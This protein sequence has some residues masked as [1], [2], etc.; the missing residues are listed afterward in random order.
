MS[1]SML[2]TIQ[3]GLFDAFDTM[4]VADGYNYNVSGGYGVQYQ[5]E[6][7]NKAQF[8]LYNVYVINEESMD[9][10]VFPNMN[11]FRN[12]ATIEIHCYNKLADESSNSVFDID[13]VLNYM[14]HDIK[15]MIGSNRTL[16]STCESIFYKR[17][18][19]VDS[20]GREDI[21]L[22]K[23]LIITAEINY[24]QDDRTPSVAAY[25]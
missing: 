6:D 8:P 9:E 11:S 16:G 17:S 18:E 4:L 1:V 20:G 12:T 21:M 19:R 5:Q 22:P 15:K 24:S 23:K 3:S 13:T 14:L 10:A 25:C 7:F 2:E